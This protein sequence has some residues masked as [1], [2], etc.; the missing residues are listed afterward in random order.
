MI[1][2]FGVAAVLISVSCMIGY[3]NNRSKEQYETVVF[4]G[5]E[6][7]ARFVTIRDDDTYILGFLE[8]GYDYTITV[9]GSYDKENETI[10]IDDYDDYAISSTESGTKL[11]LYT[12]VEDSE[13]SEI[14]ETDN[15][16]Y[17]HIEAPEGYMDIY[18]RDD[19][20][21]GQKDGVIRTEDLLEDNVTSYIV[22]A[23]GRIVETMKSKSILNTFD[24][25]WDLLWGYEVL[26]E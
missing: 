16:V 19:E 2:T 17:L 11:N 26:E 1:Y 24:K 12:A 14:I 4:N 7:S 10:Y 15:E 13:K 3:A 18:L 6:I 9:Y 8:N 25:C 21:D 22:T 23:D 5:K 20:K